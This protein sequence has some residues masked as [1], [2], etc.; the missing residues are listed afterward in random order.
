[1]NV[2]GIPPA[3]PDRREMLKKIGL[4]VG[5]SAAVLL[6]ASP[7]AFADTTS[8]SPECTFSAAADN[9][10]DQA[11]EGGDSLLGLA[12]GPV[13]N[14][15]TPANAQTQAPVTSCN[16][17]EDVLDTNIEDNVQDNDD[18]ETTV[19]DSFNTEG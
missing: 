11:G 12:A 1:M 7:L 9:S 6:A 14:L 8:R 3:I 4:I 10:V 2:V 16:N 13:T 19:E 17:I 18:T 5:G 15:G